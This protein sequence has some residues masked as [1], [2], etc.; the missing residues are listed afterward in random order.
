LASRSSAQALS[1]CIDNEIDTLT[2]TRLIERSSTGQQEDALII[3]Q[4]TKLA[5]TAT[6][7]SHPQPINLPTHT[8][9]HSNTM[10]SSAAIRSSSRA[11]TVVQS[12]SLTS[13][14]TAAVQKLQNVLEEYRQVQ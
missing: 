1:P 12:R 2:N 8:L 3:S 6:N 14:T 11:A 4:T 5:N 7:S 13:K 10:L 9:T